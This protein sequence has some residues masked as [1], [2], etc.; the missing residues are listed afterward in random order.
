MLDSFR[1]WDSSQLEFYFG[2]LVILELWIQITL[3]KLQVYFLGLAHFFCQDQLDRLKVN[4]TD[5]GAGALLTSEIGASE[6]REAEGPPPAASVQFD[7]SDRRGKEG[8]DGGERR[9]F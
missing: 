3:S 9:V 4:L 6:G 2:T 7:L 8:G 5:R 1:L